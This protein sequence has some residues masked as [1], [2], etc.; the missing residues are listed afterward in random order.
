MIPHQRQP[1]EQ[2]VL[3]LITPTCMK[4]DCSSKAIRFSSIHRVNGDQAH[5]PY[6]FV[7]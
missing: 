4:T 6:L 3:C 2:Q 1:S 5:F 7:G